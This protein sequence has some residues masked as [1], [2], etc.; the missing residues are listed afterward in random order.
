MF[1]GVCSSVLLFQIVNFLDPQ[2]IL[3]FSDDTSRDIF[4]GF[5]A[6]QRFKSLKNL[7]I[8]DVWNTKI[9]HGQWEIAQI[10]PRP[11]FEFLEA[12]LRLNKMDIPK[13]GTPEYKPENYSRGSTDHLQAKSNALVTHSNG[14][15][16]N[17]SGLA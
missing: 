8:K 2:I 15:I 12:H 4:R 14:M 13:R 3:L 5:F 17:F 6:I 1:V 16:F 9:Y 10:M 11:Q 7:P